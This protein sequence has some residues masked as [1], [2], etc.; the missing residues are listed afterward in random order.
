MPHGDI[1]VALLLYSLAIIGALALVCGLVAGVVTTGRLLLYRRR[2]ALQ[3][4]SSPESQA[5]NA[6]VP[7]ERAM[8]LGII[9]VVVF[10]PLSLPAVYYALI[11]LRRME[12]HGHDRNHYRQAIAGLSTGT[13]GITLL[14]ILAGAYI[15]F[16]VL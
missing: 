5:P 8:I 14:L 10:V 13:F 7:A 15:Y 6:S 4:R 9:S 3:T 1:G 12:K 16:C 2:L 11:A